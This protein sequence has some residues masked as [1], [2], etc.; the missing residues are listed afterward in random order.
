MMQTRIFQGTSTVLAFTSEL[1]RGENRGDRHLHRRW[2]CHDNV[3]T[4]QNIGPRIISRR[5]NLVCSKQIMAHIY[6]SPD[7]V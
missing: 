7:T 2:L 3:E 1:V 5:S 4:L 6:Y